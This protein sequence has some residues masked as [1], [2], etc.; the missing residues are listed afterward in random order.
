VTA[1][2]CA[3]IKTIIPI[4]LF[5][6]EHNRS[7]VFKG[8]IHPC[9]SNDRHQAI[10]GHQKIREYLT[11]FRLER[12][13]SSSPASQS[14]HKITDIPWLAPANTSPGIKLSRSDFNKRTELFSEFIYWLFD[15]IIIHLIRTNFYVTETAVHR[16][17]VFY[18]R[19]DIW[20]QISAPSITKLKHT[21]LAPI[22]KVPHLH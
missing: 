15:S 21:M 5:G 22:T 6:S 13:Q 8:M 20:R 16:N 12:Y 9:E 3:V 7:I 18:F 11:P 1:F 17:R 4:D 14:N 10:C 2:V 19:H